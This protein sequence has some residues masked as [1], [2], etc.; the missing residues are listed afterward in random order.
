MSE[1]PT[2]LDQAWDSLILVAT[3]YVDNP[4]S[5]LLEIYKTFA[6]HLKDG[7]WSSRQNRVFEY[8]SSLCHK[9]CE[10][11]SKSTTFSFA[12]SSVRDCFPICDGLVPL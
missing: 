6:D 12:A 10:R 9:V 5:F 3:L 2:A 1:S 7:C 8:V 4:H 11:G